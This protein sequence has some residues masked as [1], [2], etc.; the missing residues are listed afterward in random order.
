MEEQSAQSHD[1]HGR[2]LFGKNITFA[3]LTARF[4]MDGALKTSKITDTYT[5]EK[6]REHYGE[7]ALPMFIISDNGGLTVVTDATKIDPRP[8]QKLISLVKNGSDA[9]PSH[10]GVIGA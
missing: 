9:P 6:F 5:Y 2:Y 3:E 4:G 8:G 7:E 1:L 10:P